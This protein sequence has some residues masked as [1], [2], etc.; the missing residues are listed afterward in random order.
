MTCGEIE[1]FKQ[2]A[3]I[4]CVEA[5]NHEWGDRLPNMSELARALEDPL[6]PELPPVQYVSRLFL[7]GDWTYKKTDN[8]SPLRSSY[9][10]VGD[11]DDLPK[12][13]ERVF[14]PCP[15]PAWFDALEELLAL[16]ERQTKRTG[17]P[18]K[19]E[20]D[21]ER[22]VLGALATHHKC[23]GD[24]IGNPTPAKTKQLASLAS[25]KNVKVS[26]AT[27]SRFFKRKFP[28]RGYKGY[29][30]ACIRNEIGLKI[31]LWQGEGHEHLADLFPGEYGRREED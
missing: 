18:R 14:R 22:L 30:S 8:D 9:P 15:P 16:A 17:R 23:S 13:A 6:L 31:A 20:S 11:D 3:T 26:V 28:G 29:E 1:H 24:S 2:L 21:K 7:P 5:V 27:V 19:G 4:V 12:C 25:N 10:L